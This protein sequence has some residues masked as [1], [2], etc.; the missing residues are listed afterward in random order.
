MRH[1]LGNRRLSRAFDQRLALLRSIC[2]SLFIYGKVKVTVTRG[3]EAKRM[4]EKIIALAKRNDV[5]ARRQ[6]NSLVAEKSLVTQIAKTMP[7]RFEGRAGGFTRLTR[8]GFRKGDAAPI[9]L[10]ELL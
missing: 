7:E 2:R 5:H 9:A 6:I 8:L 1:G 4:A 3:K 10:L